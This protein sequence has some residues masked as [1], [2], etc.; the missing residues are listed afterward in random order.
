MYLWE[1]S[2]A[3]DFAIGW[4]H[5]YHLLCA[6][7]WSINLL[8][9]GA[10]CDLCSFLFEGCLRI[11]WHQVHED[12][13]NAPTRHISLDLMGSK[14]ESWI[15]FFTQVRWDTI[16]QY[17]EEPEQKQTHPAISMP[18]THTSLKT[19]KSNHDWKNSEIIFP[20]IDSQTL[21]FPPS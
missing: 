14:K 20:L 3:Q 11:R 5:Q 12:S 13:K 19:G 4:R 21:V 9:L 2:R 1:G 17:R 18:R 15:E 7:D 8:N 16:S 10:M 6:S